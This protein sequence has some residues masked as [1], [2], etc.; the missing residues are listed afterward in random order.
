M[1]AER[2]LSSLL[3]INNVTVLQL[4][5]QAEDQLVGMMRHDAEHLKKRNGAK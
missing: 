3:H 5:P 2:D 1:D 4:G